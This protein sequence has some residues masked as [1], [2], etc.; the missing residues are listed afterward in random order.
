VRS[1]ASY[2][3]EMCRVLTARALRALRD[4]AERAPWPDDPAMLWGPDRGIVQRAL[5]GL[6]HHEDDAADTIVTTVNGETISVTGAANKT[7]LRFL[8]EDVKLPGTKEGC[9]EGECGACT[10]FLDGMAVMACLVPAPRAHG[11]QIVTVE[12]LADVDGTLHPLQQTFIDAGAV[13][14]GYCTPGFL[15]SGAKLL[16]EHAQP[17]REQIEQSITGNLCR[18][19]GYYKIVEAFERAARTT[20]RD[21]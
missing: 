7:L 14:C 8:R 21:G 15:M 12:G 19:T 20:E 10:V 16:D 13:Q 9:A 18:C 6:V 3:T 5:P 11:A 2:R 4:G 1:G 17:T